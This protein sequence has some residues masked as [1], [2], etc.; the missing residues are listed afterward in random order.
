M[1]PARSHCKRVDAVLALPSNGGINPYRPCPLVQAMSVGCTRKARCTPAWLSETPT[2]LRMAIT[3]PCHLVRGD[4]WS[5][6][7]PEDAGY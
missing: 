6:S 2:A 3:A 1:S 4:V 7:I 5:S